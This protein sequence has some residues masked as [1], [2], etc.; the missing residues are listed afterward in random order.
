M[1]SSSILKHRIYFEDTKDNHNAK[2]KDELV[3]RNVL[4]PI[5]MRLFPA[6]S[7]DGSLTEVNTS[8]ALR[9]LDN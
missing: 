5:K 1:R 2:Q 8:R 9:A 6:F 7:T 3:F 4:C